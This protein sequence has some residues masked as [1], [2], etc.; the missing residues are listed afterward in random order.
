MGHLN[1]IS[2]AFAVLYIGLGVDYAIHLCLRYREVLRE[3]ITGAAAVAASL[4]RV[5]GSLTLCTVTTALAF[6]A[7]VPTSFAGVSE[8][9]LISGTGMVINLLLSLTLLPA[10]LCLLPAPAPLPP[11]AAAARREWPARHAGTVRLIAVLLLAGA[12]LYLPALGF[13]RNPL[14]LRDPQTES[15][16][17]VLELMADGGTAVM[18]ITVLAEDDAQATEYATALEALP[19]VLRVESLASLAPD[20]TKARRAQVESLARSLEPMLAAAGPGS[21]QAAPIA[22]REL[23][24]ALEGFDNPAAVELAPQLRSAAANPARAEDLAVRLT[25][26]LPDALGELR[27]SLRP[28][29]LAGAPLPASLR[30]HWVSNAGRQRLSVFPSEDINRNDALRRFVEAVQAVVPDAT[31]EP[32]LSLRAGDAVVAAFQQAFVFAVAAIGLLLLVLL[33]SPAAVLAILTPLAAA[34][35]L[36]AG[37]MGITGLPFNFANVIALP[38]LFGIGVDNC[39]HMVQ[40]AR[41]SDPPTRSLLATSTARAVLFSSL[42]TLCS[43][44]NL[45]FSPHPG[46][47]SMGLLLAIGVAMTILCTLVLLPAMLAGPART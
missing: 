45:L 29:A 7:F 12:V 19:E 40:R 43:F 18:S 25:G 36:T 13:D 34:C 39:I 28:A 32:V 46:T 44:G 10:L 5:R 30:S 23:A 47:A 31:D 11:P 41:E 9:G 8:L 2:I 16:A 3:G 4:H 20:L 14:K 17:T 22:L 27:A 1:L 21:P 26:G 35:L 37:I 33:R 42:T 38:L 6:Y 15:V 24:A